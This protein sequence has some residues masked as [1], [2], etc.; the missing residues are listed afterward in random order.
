MFK[1]KQT[2]KI[3]RKESERIDRNEKNVVI[4]C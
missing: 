4:A 2:S 3:K 1:L